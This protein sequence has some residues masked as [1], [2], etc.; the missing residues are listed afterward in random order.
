LS[1][2]FLWLVGLAVA[3]IAGRFVA[4]L[5]FELHPLFT[6]CGT[7]AFAFV[8]AQWIR[9]D[10][11]WRSILILG[12]SF[13]LGIWAA[14][15]VW[16][17]IY[18]SPVFLE[19]LAANGVIHHDSLNLAAF[20]NML[21]TYHVPTIG[22]D[23]LSHVSYHWGTAWMFA[24]WSSLIDTDVLS[25]YQLGFPVTMIPF[26]VGGL[27]AF[28]IAIGELRGPR[29]GDLDPRRNWVAVALLVIGLIGIIPISGL[30]A[31]GV[32][33][34]NFLISESYT[35]AVPVFLLLAATAVAFHRRHATPAQRPAD[36]VFPLVIVPLSVALLG[37]IKI[38]LMVLA[39]CALVYAVIRLRSYRRPSYLAGA[40]LAILLAALTY[41]RVSLPAHRE[42][43]AAFDF[44]RGYVPTGWWPVFFIVHLAWTW[45]YILVR[46]RQEG[47][48]TL[49]DMREALRD[50]RLV[51]V[52]LVLVIAVAGL[53][54]GL[55][56]RIDGGSAFYF[57]D[58]QR[59]LSIG[60]LI[61]VAPVLSLRSL[62][63]RG[64]SSIRVVP[65]MLALIA[66]AS[67]IIL[68]RNALI[69]PVRMA[70]ANV[71]TRLALYPPEVA[72]RVPPGLHG[73]FDLRESAKLEAGLRASDRARVAE[74][75][76]KLAALPES[77]RRR[78]AL[79]I[80]QSEAAYWEIL[81]RPGAC[82]FT[83]LV[84]P[85]LASM[86]MIDGM[87]PY[88]CTVSRYYGLGSFHPRTRMQ[89]SADLEPSTL[90][91]K[92][93]KSRLDKVLALHFDTSA[94]MQVRAINCVGVA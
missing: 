88:G 16:G 1:Y 9:R 60:L 68:A 12:G 4:A 41:P 65:A 74:A 73:F 36:F 7:L 77:E 56:L 55:L 85:A 8:L 70:R 49:A 69:W 62:M 81:A 79:F 25:F 18:K 34:S 83:P 94:R 84:A 2:P 67:A 40:L 39:V 89:N 5:P 27:L 31:M 59:W 48:R 13:G 11:W 50:R 22:V 87:P 82:T 30:D 66:I 93:R 3:S 76:R 90:C 23:G 52:E 71:E 53:A 44:I 91:A 92:A 78:T 63:F 20:A 28:G 37:Y 32:W 51:D 72:V 10:S 42:G 33:T 6:V 47:V 19:M 43:F 64:G 54:P 46:L 21:R 17:R 15:V 58:V 14:G 80:P 38:S 57:S 75:L 24:Q 26:F 61:S 86:A 35:V 45:I 29:A